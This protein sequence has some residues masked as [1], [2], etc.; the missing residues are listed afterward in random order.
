MV[1][2]T[3]TKRKG[4][5]YGARVGARVGTHTHTHA[6]DGGLEGSL[7]LNNGVGHAVGEQRLDLWRK[8]VWGWAPGT[9]RSVA[10]AMAHKK[11]GESAPGPGASNS[12][13]MGLGESMVVS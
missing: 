9:S 8:Q 1:I 10:G 13:C 2:R 7:R 11:L 3:A 5:Q 12:T 6:K 4:H